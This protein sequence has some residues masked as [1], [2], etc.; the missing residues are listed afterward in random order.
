M[1][2]SRRVDRQLCRRQCLAQN[3]T[4]KDSSPAR[5]VGLAYEEV[6]FDALQCEVGA[7]SVDGGFGRGGGERAFE[8]GTVVVGQQV[9][10]GQGEGSAKWMH[11]LKKKGCSM[12]CS[13]A[14]SCR[15][16]GWSLCCIRDSVMLLYVAV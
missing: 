3:L 16:C 1:G 15:L 2:L 6:S 13:S 12:Y 11:V 10:A 9:A 5:I 8:G 14:V 7:E 4:P